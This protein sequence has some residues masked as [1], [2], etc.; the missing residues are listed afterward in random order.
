MASF[1]DLSV[2]DLDG[3]AFQIG[4]EESTSQMIQQLRMA[5]NKQTID[6][7]PPRTVITAPIRPPIIVSPESSPHLQRS[8]ILRADDYEDEDFLEQD[9]DHA[10][11][12]SGTI[13]VFDDEY[14]TDDSTD[15]SDIDAFLDYARDVVKYNNAPYDPKSFH[16]FEQLL[17]ECIAQCFAKEDEEQDSL[18]SEKDSSTYSGYDHETGALS[19]HQKQLLKKPMISKFAANRIKGVIAS[20]KTDERGLTTI[21][22]SFVPHSQRSGHGS[23]IVLPEVEDS[24]DSIVGTPATVNLN[25]LKDSMVSREMKSKNSPA[26]VISDSDSA[27]ND[28]GKYHRRKRP[29]CRRMRKSRKEKRDLPPRN[30]PS[31]DI[32][33]TISGTRSSEGTPPG[34]RSSI[35]A[36][37]S[38]SPANKEKVLRYLKQS[39]PQLYRSVVD[40]MDQESQAQMHQLER[41]YHNDSGFL[42]TPEKSGPTNPSGIVSSPQ[43]S[44]PRISASSFIQN[45]EWKPCIDSSSVMRPSNVKN[46]VTFYAVGTSSDV[47]KESSQ[48]DHVTVSLTGDIERVLK[49][50]QQKQ[51]QTKC[52]PGYM[53]QI[54]LEDQRENHENMAVRG[55]ALIHKFRAKRKAVLQAKF[56]QQSQQGQD[57]GSKHPSTPS[58][59]SSTNSAL[60]EDRNNSP[61]QFDLYMEQAASSSPSKSSPTLSLEEQRQKLRRLKEKRRRNMP[62]EYLGQESRESLLQSESSSKRTLVSQKSS[63]SMD[64]LTSMSKSSPFRHIKF[65]KQKKKDS[66]YEALTPDSPSTSVVMSEVGEGSDD[67]FPSSK[68]MSSNSLL[69]NSEQNGKNNSFHAGGLK[70]DDLNKILIDPQSPECVS[71]MQNHSTW[72]FSDH[73]RSTH[74]E[75]SCGFPIYT[76]RGICDI[77]DVSCRV[78]AIFE[79]NNSS[80]GNDRFQS[81][82]NSSTWSEMSFQSD[83]LK[84]PS[85]SSRK[86]PQKPATKL[87]KIKGLS[88]AAISERIEEVVTTESIGL[89]SDF[90]DSFDEIVSRDTPSHDSKFHFGDGVSPAG[91]I[92]VFFQ[93][94]IHC[95]EKDDFLAFVDEGE[96]PD[97][98]FT[99]KEDSFLATSSGSTLHPPVFLTTNRF[100]I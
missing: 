81:S 78:P 97:I 54:L 7:V 23:G 30:R 96:E 88:I 61:Q 10:F 37:L 55:M 13:H 52:Q 4:E 17:G 64:G 56:L 53:R 79:D 32:K 50:M 60:I 27:G 68:E 20:K 19:F 40:R 11:C 31:K 80:T 71:P 24:D 86:H 62:S 84:F 6:H 22:G 5:S 49:G 67:C 72:D 44:V 47:L 1:A 39:A 69:S 89:C 57:Y 85:S 82:N 65:P 15:E 87:E 51:A 59:P 36:I 25:D 43:K 83:N 48:H 35:S 75:P 42:C 74:T 45:P 12:R 38:C 8:L 93:T 73:S 100:E 92:D 91:V 70:S 9:P 99:D 66:N 46:G 77:S 29:K 28:S 76:N 95:R 90:N 3:V 21:N 58:P 41:G 2:D 34:S 18:A 16:D 98:L 33:G 94:Q 14:L 26:E 63:G